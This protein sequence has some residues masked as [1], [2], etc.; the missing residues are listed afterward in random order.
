MLTLDVIVVMYL[1]GCKLKDALSV[2]TQT[3]LTVP[4]TC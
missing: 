4:E 3:P 2:R 1:Q